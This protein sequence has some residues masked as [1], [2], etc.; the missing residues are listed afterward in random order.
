[1]SCCIVPSLEINGSDGYCF[2]SR[3]MWWDDKRSI[4]PV[5]N[6]HVICSRCGVLLGEFVCLLDDF[7]VVCFQH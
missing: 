3:N 2:P 4:L 1:M 6:D 5:S 7:A